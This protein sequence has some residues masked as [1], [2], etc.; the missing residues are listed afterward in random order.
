VDFRS[1]SALSI[2]QIAPR[3]GIVVAVRLAYVQVTRADAY[4]AAG[5]VVRLEEAAA[6]AVQEFRRRPW[7]DDVEPGAVTPLSVSVKPPATTHEVSIKQLE[8]WTAMTLQ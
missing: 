3:I 2:H 4:A 1:R 6:L 5:N 8:K 7:V